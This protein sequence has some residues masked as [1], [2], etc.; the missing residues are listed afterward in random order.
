MTALISCNS[1]QEPEQSEQHSTENTTTENKS[2]KATI[3]KLTINGKEQDLETIFIEYT[4]SEDEVKIPVVAAEKSEGDGELIIEQATTIPGNATVTLNEVKYTIMFSSAVEYENSTLQ[5]TYHKLIS[6]ERFNVAYI[7]GS[8]TVG[9][10]ADPNTEAYRALTTKWFRDNF[11]ANIIETA[12]GIGG[13]GSYWGAYRAIEHLKLDDEKAKPD[14]V[15][16]EFAVNDFYDNATAEDIKRNG[17][18]IINEIYKANPKADIIIL[19]TAEKTLAANNTHR[20]TWRAVAEHYN[21]PVVELGE[22]IHE[23]ISKNGEEWTKYFADVV[24]P[25]KTGHALYA[26]YVTDYLK[27]ELLD[28]SVSPFVSEYKVLPDTVLSNDII[29]SPAYF[30]PSELTTPAGFNKYTDNKGGITSSTVGAT[31]KFTFSGTG[32]ILEFGNQDNVVLEY[33]IDGKTYTDINVSSASRPVL[34]DD[35]DNGTHT[36]E[37]K[38]KSLGAGAKLDIKRIFVNGNTSRQPIT[39]LS[40]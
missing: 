22:K 8:I 15:F 40:N 24:H 25:N 3:T 16:I 17:E 20:A 34:A 27:S 2:Q 21:L 37:I 30:E 10:M 32:L 39:I 28:K 26:Q 38:I 7:G 9:A 14:L 1:T 11:D 31:L 19:I 13:T 29:D 6:G 18:T 5:N 4:L 12:A 23:H 36:V 35:L 33:T